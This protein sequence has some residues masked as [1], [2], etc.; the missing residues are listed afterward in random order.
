MGCFVFAGE[1]LVD[2][3]LAIHGAL[4]GHLDRFVIVVVDLFVIGRFGGE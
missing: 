3:R 4:D 1:H 2:R